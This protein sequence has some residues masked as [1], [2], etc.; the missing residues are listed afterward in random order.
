[1]GTTFFAQTLP[2][3][4]Q[5]AP[6]ASRAGLLEVFGFCILLVYLVYFSVTTAGLRATWGKRLL[7]LEVVTLHPGKLTPLQCLTR[8]VGRV[9]DFALLPCVAMALLFSARKMRIGDHIASTQVVVSKRVREFDRLVPA[10]TFRS[11]YVHLKPRWVESTFCEVYLRLYAGDW[12]PQT[13]R[14]LETM[15][16]EALVHPKA[17]V[18]QE[19]LIHFFAEFCQQTL[20]NRAESRSERV[21]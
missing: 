7:G 2:V 15:A 3:Q 20:D 6:L 21:G 11:L 19:K 16:R 5:A 10:S 4:D 14:D 13:I 18:E 17:P 1:M 9:L 8:E 12:T